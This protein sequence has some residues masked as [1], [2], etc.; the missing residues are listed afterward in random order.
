MPIKECLGFCKPYEIKSNFILL[1]ITTQ[2][3]LRLMHMAAIFKTTLSN[4]IEIWF[5][6]AAC[7]ACLS[8]Y[9]KGKFTHRWYM[10]LD[11]SVKGWDIIQTG[12]IEIY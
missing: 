12:Q 9:V 3:F 8:S 10:T 2:S 6:R 1:R 4:L 7:N 11:Y 5:L